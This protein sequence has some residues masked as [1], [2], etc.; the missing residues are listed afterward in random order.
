MLRVISG[1]YKSRKIKEVKSDATRPT[2]DKNKEVLFNTLGQFFDEGR[3]LDLYAGSGALGIEAYSRGYQKIDFVDNNFLAIKTIKANL[4][5]LGIDS[6]DVVVHKQDALEYLRKAKVK[7]DLVIIDPPYKMDNYLLILE[8]LSSGQLL[9]D[10]GII[11][12]ES[13]NAKVFPKE[14]K[15]FNLFKEKIMGY[16]KFSFY[17]KEPNI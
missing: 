15:E 5:S 8:L 16:S 14:Y 10:N 9:N 17:K 7:Y 12:M 2:T 11:V 3:M 1:K 6:N 4:E 13:D